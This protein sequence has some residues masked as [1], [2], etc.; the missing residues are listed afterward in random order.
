[1]GWRLNWHH[2]HQSGLINLFM[3]FCLLFCD[4]LRD[5]K[6][7]FLSVFSLLSLSYKQN[8]PLILSSGKFTSF[9]ETPWA[10]WKKM[11]GNMGIW[12]N[13]SEN[14]FLHRSYYVGFYSWC[15]LRYVRDP[16]NIWVICVSQNDYHGYAD[17]W[18][19]SWSYDGVNSLAVHAS[20]HQAKKQN[21]NFNISIT[22]SAQRGN[23]SVVDHVTER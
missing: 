13:V 9:C 17:S 2:Q 8:V 4:K 15:I 11:V 22:S 6:W 5:Y 23:H 7:L 19:T 1:M 16:P 3:L 21:K 20:P 10:R 18:L 12:L 14:G